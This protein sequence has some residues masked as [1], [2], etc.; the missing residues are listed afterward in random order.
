MRSAFL[1]VVV[2]AATLLCMP[3][4]MADPASFTI[5]DTSPEVSA[6]GTVSLL[7]TNLTDED[8]DIVIRPRRPDAG[9]GLVAQPDTL[10]RA[11]PTTVTITIPETCPVPDAGL[12][13][14]VIAPATQVDVLAKAP[15]PASASSWSVLLVFPAVFVLFASLAIMLWRRQMRAHEEDELPYLDAAWSF[16]DSWAGNVTVIGGLLTGVVG[17]S[18]VVKALLGADADQSIA[19]ATVGA[20][21]AVAFVA[22]A[23][24]LLLATKRNKVFRVSGLFAAA[25]LTLSGAVGEL[26][27][28]TESARALDLDGWQNVVWLPCLAAVVLL[29]V[30]SYRTV[31]QTVADGT[32]APPPAPESDAIRAAKLVVAAIRPG[33]QELRTRLAETAAAVTALPKPPGTRRVSGSI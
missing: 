12:R 7:V 27:V 8:L 19:L 31:H 30:Y 10:P 23:P 4:A 28:V 3:R 5:D 14:L 16:K 2:I 21:I 20:A 17:S 1:V 33:D 15:S 18:D 11:Q 32:T 29:L 25:T 9:C 13:L 22:A 24:V 26:V 6:D